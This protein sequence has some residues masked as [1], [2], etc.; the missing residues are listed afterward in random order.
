MRVHS[1]HDTGGSGGNC[2]QDSTFSG[3]TGS[4][5]KRS[6]LL[7]ERVFITS[8]C[9]LE[10]KKLLSFSFVGAVVRIMWNKF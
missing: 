9:T 7:L 3:I 10:V 8:L 5:S 6:S 1:N 2:L 4:S